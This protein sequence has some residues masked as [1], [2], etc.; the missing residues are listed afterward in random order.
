MLQQ[1]LP[2]IGENFEQ[3]LL[4]G[5]WRLRNG[6]PV[7]KSEASADLISH[8]CMVAEELGVP[9]FP[10]LVE[11]DPAHPGRT[12]KL[13]LIKEWQN[14]GAVTNPEAIENLF[15]QHPLATHVGLQTGERSRLLVIDLDG[16]L[17]LKWWREHPELLPMTRTQQTQ[18]EGGRHLYYR[19]PTGCKL[20]N[21]AGKIAEGVDVRADGGFVVDWSPLYPPKVEDIADAPPVLIEFLERITKNHSPVAL[22]ERA[23]SVYKVHEHGRHDA[24]KSVAASL[25]RKG[26]KGPVLE[27]ALHAWNIEHCEPPQDQQDVSNLARDF[28]L[29]DGDELLP[30]AADPWAP[31]AV[32]TYG[33]SFDPAKIPLRRW[34]IRGRYARGEGTVIAGPPG[35]NKSTLLLN[36]AVALATGRDLLGDII[37]E[38]GASLFLAGE[39]RRRDV[40]ARLA[41]ICEHYQIAPAELGGR[42]HVVYQ[43]EINPVD[44]TLASMIKDMSAL[45]IQMFEW[46]GQYPNLVALFIDPMISWHRLIE[47]DTGAMDLISVALRGLASKANIAVVFDHH[48]TKLAQFDCE[49]HVGNLA[50]MRGSSAIAASTRWAFTMA[51]LKPETAA[52]YGIAEADRPFF[53]RLDGLKASYGPDAGEPRL[54][55]VRSVLIANGETVGVLAPV[56]TVQLVEDGKERRKRAEQAQQKSLTEAL[57]FMLNV[58][59]PRTLRE[60]ATWLAA[61]QPDVFTG[62][63]GKPLA[64]RSIRERLESAIGDGLYIT[65]N[66]EAAKIVCE[67][68]SKTNTPRWQ[69]TRTMGRP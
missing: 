56:D 20:R 49:A 14:G 23:H 1:S 19:T 42:L 67:D 30:D 24:L 47:N 8:A 13:P 37:D 66:D 50:A 60:A 35:T 61:K 18:R 4:R 29:K 65:H 57:T 16:E 32:S 58:K 54:L 11:R 36:D 62:K 43:S 17:G 48:V 28:S 53:R 27:A 52:H 40:E 55:H 5:L 46:L 45:N 7:K 64:A 6:T 26:L 31:P 25:R 2:T 69:I 22:R 38:A 39:D 12:R 10:V 9:V 51:R 44:Y 41:G 15:S 68:T 21:S 63:D 3:S 34:L 33:A 59:C